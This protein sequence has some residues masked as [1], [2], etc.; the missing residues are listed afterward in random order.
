MIAMSRF[1]LGVALAAIGPALAAPGQPE[2]GFVAFSEHCRAR[3][4][5]R[6]FTLLAWMEADNDV[7]R[8]WSSNP[9]DYPISARKQMGVT[10]WGSRVLHRRQLWMGRNAD[11]IRWAFPDHV[12]IERLGCAAC[13][14]ALVVW[15]GQ[16]LGV[17]AMLDAENAYTEEDMVGL[18]VIAPLLAPGFL[19]FHKVSEVA[20]T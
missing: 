8:I 7:Q 11:D 3:V 18:N 15:D 10:E 17:V 4:G 19:A 1:D 9:V 14:N 20:S 2:T 5:H 16:L 13:I 12:L 6:L